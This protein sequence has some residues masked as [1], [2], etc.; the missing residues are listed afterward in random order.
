LLIFLSFYIIIKFHKKWKDHHLTIALFFI[1]VIHHII[2]LTNTY[3]FIIHGA[4]A[5]A[6][7]FHRLG[8]EW[9]MD[10]KWS[11]MVGAGFY[12]Q[13]L[14]IF[15]RIFEPSHLLGEELSIIAFFFACFVLIKLIDFLNITKYR[16]GL[17]LMFGLLP[18]NLV[19]GSVTMRESYQILFFMLSVYW[20]LRFHLEPTKGAMIFCVFS[21]IIMG[22][23]HKA[24]ILYMLFL[25]P[26][27]FLWFPKK[28]SRFP[29]SRWIFPRKRFI[30]IGA[31]LILIIGIL[32]MG[33][34]SEIQGL[35]TLSSVFSGKGLKYTVDYRT[36][37]MTVQAPDARANY[38]IMLDTSSWG[39]LIKTTSLAYIYYL[40]APF[41][42]QVKNWFDFYALADSFFRFI[43]I[44]IGI[45]FWYRAEGMKRRIWGL[46]LVIYFSM[47]FL[48][49][50]GTV[51]YGTSIR[52]HILTNWIII[53]LGG[54]VLID[55]V[56]RQFGKKSPTFK[57]V[58]IGV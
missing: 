30:I 7:R 29:E 11:I 48:W 49:A 53:I 44:L 1:L 22:L 57:T 13:F 24:L 9:A 28:I 34:R 4:D 51:N 26:V 21:A 36:N 31:I 6:V 5:D 38:G 35:E 45:F 27:L 10:G 19:L 41:P 54:P 37:L 20:G 39:S 50:M 16:V 40:F 14:G 25:L 56:L 17:L 23:F 2:A 47:T 18:T 55:F 42:W 58:K 52:H 46:L 32:I 15:Y 12:Q 8:V 33:V 3:L 43:L